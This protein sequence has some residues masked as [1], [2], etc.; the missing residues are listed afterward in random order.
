M[1][2][3]VD[4]G[5]L[6]GDCEQIGKLIAAGKSAEAARW[7]PIV[8]RDSTDPHEIAFARLQQMA[9]LHNMGMTTRPVFA[10]AGRET[11]AALV[12][13][14]AP[15]LIGHYHVMMAAHADLTGDLESAVANLIKAEVAMAAEP[16]PSRG[17]S[18]GW[19]QLAALQS[20]MGLARNA[21]DSLDRSREVGSHWP[22]MGLGFYP[23]L[24]A[25][26][27]SDQ[28]GATAVCARQLE[29]LLHD[30][31]PADE[32]GRAALNHWERQHLAYAAARL[33]ALGGEPGVD[34]RRLMSP[35]LFEEPEA[36]V[37]SLMTLACLAIAEGDGAAAVALLDPIALDNPVSPTELL[38][39]RSLALTVIGDHAGALA[40]ERA[41]FQALSERMNGL[42]H[43]LVTQSADGQERKLIGESLATYAVAALTDP[44]TGLPNRRHLDQQLAE[45]L[46][47]SQPAMLGLLDLDRF[48][49]VNTVHG[50]VVGDQVLRVVADVV[51]KALR[52]QDFVARYGGDEFV[53]LMPGA[54]P[55]EAHAAGTRAAAA[56]AAQNW[57]AIA[58]GTPVGL[59]IGWTDLSAHRTAHTALAAA[60]QAMYDAKPRVQLG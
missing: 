32:S 55:A 44:L 4:A 48:K 34:P 45:V 46:G 57:D 31:L 24:E 25:A 54:T 39:L 13:Y 7:A 17:A 51:P 16:E 47:R 8:A 29:E 18:T 38:R 10:A 49:E 30:G 2:T 58:P 21:F 22:A 3:Y 60:D 9:A 37:L 50:H 41:M 1:A 20:S 11:T 56:V 6:P 26:L 27:W 23:A 14:P 42:R 53:V 40:V 43:I 28:Q 59:T 12:R 5:R 33:A 19:H 52:S 35:R 15:H 36:Q